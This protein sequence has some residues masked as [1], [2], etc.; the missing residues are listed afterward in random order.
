[1]IQTHDVKPHGK[2]VT[3]TSHCSNMSDAQRT[4]TAHKHALSAESQVCRSS[5]LCNK[6][7]HISDCSQKA[8][9]YMFRSIK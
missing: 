3:H 5:Q 6:E 8:L 4:V 9:M 7:C 1:M 2:H